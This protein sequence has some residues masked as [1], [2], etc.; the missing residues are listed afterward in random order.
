[1][2]RKVVGVAHPADVLLTVPIPPST[3]R[4]TT[5]SVHHHRHHQN[6]ISGS[7]PVAPVHNITHN[8]TRDDHSQQNKSWV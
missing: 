5:S 8:T 6:H 3:T 7:K 1:M 2:A 4:T